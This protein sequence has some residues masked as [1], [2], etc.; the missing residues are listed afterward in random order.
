MSYGTSAARPREDNRGGDDDRRR[1]RGWRRG[2]ECCER[3][4]HVTRPSFSCDGFSCW[5]SFDYLMLVLRKRKR[6]GGLRLPGLWYAKD[7]S[8]SLW[9]PRRDR[10]RR[11]PRGKD[12][13]NR[14]RSKTSCAAYD[15]P[16]S[17]C[18]HAICRRS[19]RRRAAGAA[20]AATLRIATTRNDDFQLTERSMANDI[21]DTP[22]HELFRQTVR[23]FVHD[24]LAP[25]AREFDEMGR[26][27]KHLYKKMGDLGMLGL[28]YDPKW[29]GAG[30]DWSYTAVMFEEI[31]RCDNAG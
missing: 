21:Y 7:R 25:R 16:C 30:L 9:R 6:P 14:S 8:V 3:R 13:N 19:R 4:H 11:R 12:S 20:V 23:K 31:V 27:D 10:G 24:E 18:Q 26:I 29:G 17:P 28:R 15:G 2:A 22:E 5:P 1:S